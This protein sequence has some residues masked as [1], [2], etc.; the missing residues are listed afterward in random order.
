MAQKL[1][2]LEVDRVDVV[3]RGANN[4]VFM[5]K[6]A[7][8]SATAQ[9]VKTEGGVDYSEADFAHAPDPHDPTQWKFRLTKEPGKPHPQ[10]VG[11]AVSGIGDNGYQGTNGN[12]PEEDMPR[13]KERIRDAWRRLHPDLTDSDMPGEIREDLDG[14]PP[15]QKGASEDEPE[16]QGDLTEEDGTVSKSAFS[17]LA[18]WARDI[19]RKAAGRPGPEEGAEDMGMT[20]DEVKKAMKE[21]VDEGLLTFTER[22]DKIEKSIGD[23]Q[24]EAGAEGVAKAAGPFVKCSKCGASI[25]V[26]KCDTV[27]KAGPGDGKDTEG[28]DAGGAAKPGDT[29]G[30]YSGLAKADVTKAVAEAV[31][32]LGERLDRIEKTQGQRQS[33]VTKS[34]A[35]IAA[36]GKSTSMWSGLI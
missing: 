19:I 1:T 26:S 24:D 28:M 7:V 4:R 9:P 13:V 30:T 29:E 23:G 36:E 6:K 11:Q 15:I 17:G 21:A 2:D 35:E 14:K 32:P 20:A 8:H 5:V 12:I 3:G 33:N 18:R 31:A 10:M 27:E 22:L 16:D 34:A 25:D